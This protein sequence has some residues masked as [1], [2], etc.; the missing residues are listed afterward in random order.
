[1][2]LL[3]KYVK[4]NLMINSNEKNMKRE[5]FKVNIITITF[6]KRKINCTNALLKKNAQ[7]PYAKLKKLTFVLLS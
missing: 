1:M 7:R 5:Y 4:W 6:G 3:E 2:V